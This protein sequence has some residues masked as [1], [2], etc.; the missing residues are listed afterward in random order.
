MLIGQ[1]WCCNVLSIVILIA[2]SCA[3]AYLE[4]LW[5]R[6]VF[7]GRRSRDPQLGCALLPVVAPVLL[8]LGLATLGGLT[9]GITGD[10]RWLFLS[11]PIVIGPWFYLLFGDLF[12]LNNDSADGK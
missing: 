5:I 4:T 10:A 6:R 11:G 1:D 7:P 3:I 8:F 12:S 2:T 9:L